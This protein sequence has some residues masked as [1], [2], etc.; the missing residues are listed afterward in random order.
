MFDAPFSYLI[1]LGANTGSLRCEPVNLIKGTIIIRDRKSY[2]VFLTALGRNIENADNK[3]QYLRGDD[4]KAFGSEASL[5]LYSHQE[6]TIQWDTVKR[7]FKQTSQTITPT[8]QFKSQV[9]H[10]SLPIID[11][12][13]RTIGYLAYI[14]QMESITPPILS[15][16]VSHYNSTPHTQHS[17]M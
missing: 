7:L 3:I 4:E 10:R 6:P 8:N 16:V 17:Q 1:R 14:H 12:V 2:P 9:N 13:I 15:Q 5:E 11:R